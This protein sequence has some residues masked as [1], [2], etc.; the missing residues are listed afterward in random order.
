MLRLLARP[1]T[2]PFQARA[3]DTARAGPARLHLA[4]SVFAWL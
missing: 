2:R 1:A 3:H 4:R